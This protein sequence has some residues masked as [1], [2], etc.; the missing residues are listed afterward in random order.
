[1]IRILT[2]DEVDAGGVI[3]GDVILAG[4]LEG[5]LYRFGAWEDQQDV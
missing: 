5:G 3:A 1:V 4:E 2:R